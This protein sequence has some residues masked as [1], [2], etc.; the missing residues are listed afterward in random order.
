MNTSQ[1]TMIFAFDS[2]R[3]LEF[4]TSKGGGHTTQWVSPAPIPLGVATKVRLG[5]KL[6]SDPSVG[7]I[8]LEVN[9]Q[10][11]IP[12]KGA[13]VLH[14]SDPDGQSVYWK[15]GLYRSQSVTGD[16]DL[17]FNGTQAFEL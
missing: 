9:D 14:D 5:V 3:K 15:Q 13:A 8:E 6:S 12:R 16:A 17:S 2:Q 1:P 10:L 4:K 11:V 7:W